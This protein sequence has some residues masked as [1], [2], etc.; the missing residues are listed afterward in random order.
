MV[1]EAEEKK[2]EEVIAIEN[3]PADYK[4]EVIQT[5]ACKISMDASGNIH[6]E[7]PKPTDKIK[8]SKQELDMLQGLSTL[9]PNV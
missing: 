5:E 8:I 4:E 2:T 6:I 9:V 3:Q 1:D 7:C